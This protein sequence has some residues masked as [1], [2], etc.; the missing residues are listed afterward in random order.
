MSQATVSPFTLREAHYP[1]DLE[2]LRAVREPVFVIEQQCPLD[3]EWDDLDPVSRH[4]IALDADGRPVGTGRL[5]PEHKIGRM[6]VLARARGIGVGAAVLERLIS[7]A[8]EIGYA[9]I[10][11]HAQT[12]AI[13][14]YARFGFQSE[15]PEFDEAGIAHRVMRMRLDGA[16][17]SQ[18]HI[19]L[20]RAADCQRVAIELATRARHQVWIA[21]SD[22]EAAVYDNEELVNAIKRVA[23]SGR[24]AAIRILV[25]DISVALQN[26]HRLLALAQRI[27]SLIE[28]RR[29]REHESGDFSASIMLND[30]GGWMRRADRLSY[31]GEGHLS[32]RPRQRELL[33]VFERAWERAE[34]ETSARMLKL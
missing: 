14:F 3:E 10:S 26:G 27:S 4:V 24:G 16:H 28:I 34:A 25:H 7:M 22:L 17:S 20:E 5:T 30:A 11:M 18:Q 8:R 32:D 12:H 33:M 19:V 29:I 23:L 13:P 1:A 15:G 6:A 31:D 2:L 9:S 21:S